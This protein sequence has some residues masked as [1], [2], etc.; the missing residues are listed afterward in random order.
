MASSA[1]GDYDPTADVEP[2]TEE[3]SEQPIAQ[4]TAPEPRPRAKRGRPFGSKKMANLCRHCMDIPWQEPTNAEG[5]TWGLAREGL[6]LYRDKAAPYREWAPRRLFC[7][8]RAT[9]IVSM[10]EISC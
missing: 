6:I 5:A 3:P 4:G 2:E 9:T 1:D 8:S 7:C 10:C